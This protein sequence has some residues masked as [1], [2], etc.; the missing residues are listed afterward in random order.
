VAGAAP[1]L[2]VEAVWAATVVITFSAWL[3]TS[4]APKITPTM[5]SMNSSTAATAAA[6]IAA[7]RHGVSGVLLRMYAWSTGRSSSPR[8][9]PLLLSPE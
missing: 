9:R 6:T 1:V 3:L 8:S 5:M 2:C 7:V 4:F